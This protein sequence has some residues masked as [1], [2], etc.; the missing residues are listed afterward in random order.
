LYKEF[1]DYTDGLRVGRSGREE[2][3]RGGGRL[4]ELCMRILLK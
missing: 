3:K 2:N 1:P 4:E